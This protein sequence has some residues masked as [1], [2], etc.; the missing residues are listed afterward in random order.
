MSSSP[1]IISS[2]RTLLPR[3]APDPQLSFKNRLPE[4]TIIRKKLEAISHEQPG[5]LPVMC[6]WGVAGIGKS[7]L[8]AELERRYR[9]DGPESGDFLR[10]TV[11]ARLDLDRTST[12]ALWRDGKLDR[13]RIIRELWRQLAEQIGDPVPDDLEGISPEEQAYRFVHRLTDRLNDC[14]PVILFD[15]MDD[16]VRDD[17]ASFAWLEENLIERL[18]LTDRVLL[19]FASR[20]ELRRWQ[21]FQVRRRVD[22]HPLVTFDALTAGEAVEANAQ[23]SRALYRHAFGHP[24]ATEYLARLEGAGPRSQDSNRRAGG[25]CSDASPC[26]GRTAGGHGVHLRKST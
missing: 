23:V 17:E 16:V 9:S 15:T 19:V 8:L 18:A 4:L 1:H 12:P 13:S 21:R 3:R 10:P 5:A 25:G 2:S 24:L 7:W 26:A 11:A 14:T 6:F 20:G 22:L